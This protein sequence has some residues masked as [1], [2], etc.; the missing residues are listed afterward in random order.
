MTLP[1]FFSTLLPWKRHK[2]TVL[3]R[4]LDSDNAIV[5]LLKQLQQHLLIITAKFPSDIET[6]NTS[7]IKVD[8]KNKLF[9]LDEL[10]PQSG[11]E[12]IK[13]TGKV[14]LRTRLDGAILTAECR[15]K[16]VTRE[17]GLNYFIMHFPRQIKSTQ[18]R[19]SY[20]VSIPLNKRYQVN[21]QTESGQ[22]IAGFLNNISFSGL[23]IR[24]EPKQKLELRIGEIVP[25]LTLHLNEPI[26][27]EMEIKR[28]SKSMGKTIVSG[29]LEEISPSHQHTIQR[30]IT[31]LDREKRKHNRLTNQSL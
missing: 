21:M 20:R 25:F 15:L 4:I 27:C 28:I 6:Y 7:V 26:T 11:N 12:Q 8:Y 30:F 5:Q 29:H 23:A 9:Y 18:R 3:R 1:R 14:L 16:A 22:F 13:K 19:D 2:K 24:L 10:I 31:R 17:K